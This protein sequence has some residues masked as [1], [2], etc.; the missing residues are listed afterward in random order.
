M[1]VTRLH[2]YL[3]IFLSA[4]NS[5]G[6][7]ASRAAEFTNESAKVLTAVTSYVKGLPAHQGTRVRPSGLFP[8]RRVRPTGSF[9]AGTPADVNAH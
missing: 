3:L 8:S 1:I 7:L 6:A 4:A 2:E 5:A 9:V